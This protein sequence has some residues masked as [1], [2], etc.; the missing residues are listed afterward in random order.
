MMSQSFERTESNPAPTVLRWLELIE[1]HG[2]KTA[3]LEALIRQADE[4]DRLKRALRATGMSPEAIAA[5]A[6]LDVA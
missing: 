4:L 2:S 6:Q 3:A 5:G 1:R